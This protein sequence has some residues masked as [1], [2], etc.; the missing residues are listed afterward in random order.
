MN[1][2][3]P[4]ALEFLP[5]REE[6]IDSLLEIEHEAYPEPWTRSMFRDELN[7]KLSYF[8]VVFAGERIA[9]YTGFWLVLDEA[10][11]TTVVVKKEFRGQGLGRRLMEFILN[12]AVE[13]GAR[14]ATLEVRISNRR[15]RNLYDS[16]GFH[17]A[18]V[19]RGYYPQTGEDAIVMFKELDA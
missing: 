4:Q 8:Y 14:I 9:G 13:V 5:L 6:H 15:A 1:E 16:L 11:I 12:K 2:P 3:A 7:N 18:G 10:H 17:I 19:R